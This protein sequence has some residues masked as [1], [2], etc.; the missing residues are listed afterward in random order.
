MK[1]IAVIGLLLLL[2]TGC[3]QYGNVELGDSV[4]LTYR[5]ATSPLPTRS[6]VSDYPN[7]PS[8]WS[9]AERAA[10]GRYFYALS[11]YILNDN[12]QIVAAQENIPVDNEATEAVVTFDKSYNLKRG[13]YTIMAVANHTSHNIDNTTYSSGLNGTWQS[14]DYQSLI[15]NVINA[16]SSHNLSPRSVMQPLSMMKTV[17]L[18]AGNNL[19]SGELVRTFA[20]LRIEVKNNSGTQP[21]NIG[22]LTFSDNFTQKQAYVFDDGSDRKYFGAKGAPQS[23]S[24]LAIQPFT[25]D[26]KII[27][28]RTSK[29]VF[30][31]YLLESKLDEG[32]FYKYTLDLSYE[33]T[34][35]TYS[36]EP[37]W[38]AINQVNNMN[39][40]EESYFLLY[41][42]NRK[43]YLSADN[44]KV[45]TAT[46]STSSSTVATDHVWQLV[47]TGQSNKY[48]ILN[49]ESGLYMQAPTNSSI[50]LGANPVAF[51][52]ASKTSGRNTY[53]TMMGSNNSCAYVG[54]SNASYAVTGYSSN[55]NSG[56]YF[57][58]YK[59]NK[60]A[61]S[62]ESNFISYNTPII[63]TTIDP[64]TQQSS[65]TRAIKRNDF[66][67]VLVTVSYN[68]AAG[69]F[70]FHV[71]DWNEGGGSVEFD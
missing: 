47:P 44:D 43:R 20:R 71:E 65:P 37:N 15:N 52:F 58:L 18:H 2:L 41:N 29:V 57:T 55:S 61:T 66:I 34:L 32:D 35:A 63:L 54:N 4:E 3:E 49:V 8:Q 36:F 39:V 21:L 14:A 68:S 11:V 50:P 5:I 62:T 22:S 60:T 7:T 28:A 46:L 1:P 24:E 33:G 48:Y 70:D 53:I 27:E 56:V 6:S 30:D 42:S 9:Q 69:K 45:G 13:I 64:V 26:A 16:H 19:L 23:T 25:N 17:E 38:T 40:G 12:K 67:N 59:V 51:T 31:S 10:D